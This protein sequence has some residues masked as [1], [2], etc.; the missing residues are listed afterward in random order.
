MPRVIIVTGASGSGKST[1]I[2]FFLEAKCKRYRPE[3]LKK[4]KTRKKRKAESHNEDGIFV[5]EIPPQCDLVYEQYGDRYGIQLAS[6]F[7]K[8]SQGITPIIILNDVRVVQDVKT[9]LG[10]CV[11]SVYL[12]RLPPLLEE[13]EKIAKQR[14]RDIGTDALVRFNKANA[15]YRIFIENINLFDHVILNSW[16]LEELRKQVNNLVHGFSCDL[17]WPLKGGL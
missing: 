2:N 15:V 8:L 14:Q 10:L 5:S 3:L 4:Y 16:G 7:E 17:H 1:A 11:S 9:A 13:Y 6:I 12:F